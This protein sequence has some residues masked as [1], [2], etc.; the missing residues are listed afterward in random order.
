MTY[1]IEIDDDDLLLF[2][3]WLENSG[4]VRLAAS[5]RDQVEEQKRNAQEREELIDDIATN[6]AN[7]LSGKNDRTE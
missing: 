4:Q 7:T 2:L 1:R 6:W 5:V 3:L